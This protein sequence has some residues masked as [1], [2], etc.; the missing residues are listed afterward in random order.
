MYSEKPVQLR[1]QPKCYR[2]P[3]SEIKHR[4]LAFACGRLVAF[5]AKLRLPLTSGFSEPSLLLGLEKGW[6]ACVSPMRW[7]KTQ[8]Q[9]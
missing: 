3:V 2:S 1:R 8:N 4:E 5:P 9:Q 6:H 7:N